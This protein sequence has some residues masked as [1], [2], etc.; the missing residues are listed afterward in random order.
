MAS[1]ENRRVASV[2]QQAIALALCCVFCLGCKT[3]WSP[4]GGPEPNFDRLIQIEQAQ[5]NSSVAYDDELE[6]PGEFDDE[7]VG[8][9]VLE[10][11]AEYQAAYNES[12][13]EDRALLDRFSQRLGKS[14]G[15]S[16]S[17]AKSD[18]TIR[19]ADRPSADD[20]VLKVDEDSA[21]FSMSDI[22][23]PKVDS[24][25]KR[26]IE[27]QLTTNVG[28]RDRSI[29]QINKTR[30]Q[31]DE[32]SVVPAGAAEDRTSKYT[33]VLNAAHAEATSSS[34]T[35]EFKDAPSSD[36]SQYYVSSD[37]LPNSGETTIREHG[38]AIIDL[39]DKQIEDTT[40]PDE[41]V[42]L[43]RN[44]RL[45]SFVLEDLDAAQAPIEGLAQETQAYFQNL[46][47]GLYDATDINGN[48]V[49]SRRL[50]LALQSHRKAENGLSRLA[51]LEV[52]NTAFCT[53]V[54]SFGVVTPFADYRFQPEQE[55]LLYCELENFVS[56]KL[57][58][59]FETQL[60]GSYEIIDR[61]GKRIADQLLPE[62][63]DVCGNQRSDFYIAYRLH[64]PSEIEPGQYK[65]KLIIEDMTGH[66]FGQSTL[67][68]HIVR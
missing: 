47:Q 22:S 37:A 10:T 60:Q 1:V 68:F 56:R 59:G 34:Q 29:S 7:P 15:L 44:R 52:N 18:S 40:N 61:D 19:S 53:E 39:L 4:M 36:N 58:N 42:L 14:K 30:A 21:S 45:I 8:Q 28:R 3:P 11:D 5:K 35:D 55:V 20:I 57:K 27:S 63:T 2:N 31:S 64:L 6:P 32:E 46:L 38:H 9:G 51:N 43:S 66:K 33:E 50:T 26:R 23:P 24:A 25:R 12:S 16:D 62:D 54:D 48:P 49:A 65:L 13:P 41:R 17:L 67:D